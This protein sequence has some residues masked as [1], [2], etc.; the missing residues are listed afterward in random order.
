[1]GPR[2][3]VMHQAS[4]KHN[5][6]LV[7]DEPKDRQVDGERRDQKLCGKNEKGEGDKKETQGAGHALSLV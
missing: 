4:Q 3:N 5:A 7:T 2:R 6:S 1:M